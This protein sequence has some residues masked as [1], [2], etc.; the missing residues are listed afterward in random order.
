MLPMKTE[1][2]STA[3]GPHNSHSYAGM[4]A[5]DIIKGWHGTPV[6]VVHR[7]LS[8]GALAT[9]E[10]CCWWAISSK[11]FFFGAVCPLPPGAEDRTVVSDF[12]PWGLSHPGYI[13]AIKFPLDQLLSQH[14]FL[15]LECSWDLSASQPAVL[16]WQGNKWVQLSPNCY[17][18]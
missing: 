13:S 16:R 5:W 10:S 18:C 7:L 6:A 2:L 1:N 8:Y 9:Q 15:Y 12:I 17:M 4:I 3:H 11:S 14:R